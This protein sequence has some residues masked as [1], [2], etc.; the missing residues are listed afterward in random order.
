MWKWI[1]DMGLIGGH[2]GWTIFD[3]VSEKDN[4]SS[5]AHT[6]WSY[7]FGMMLNTAAVM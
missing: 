7:N 3:G 1:D 4:C 2:L 5:V 6:Q